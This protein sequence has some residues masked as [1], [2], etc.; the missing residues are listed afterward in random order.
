MRRNNSSFSE[1][2][3]TVVGALFCPVPR[4]LPT[5]PPA[6]PLLQELWPPWA[7]NLATA[8]PHAPAQAEPIAV[9][10]PGALLSFQLDTSDEVMGSAENCNTSFCAVELTAHK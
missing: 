2:L 5:V 8:Q 7:H 3:R 1:V 9:I 6:E 4:C 10:L